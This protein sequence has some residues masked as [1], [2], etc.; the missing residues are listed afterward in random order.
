MKNL[1][2]GALVWILIVSATPA[3]GAD[4]DWTGVYVG[5]NAGVGVNDSKYR[6]QTDI[7]DP[8]PGF[9]ETNGLRE[10]NQ[11]LNDTAFTGG[12]QAGYNW[13]VNRFVLASSLTSTTTALTKQASSIDLWHPRLRGTSSIMPLN[14]STGSGP[15]ADVSASRHCR[16]GL[17]TR[18]AALRTAMSVQRRLGSSRLLRI[19]MPVLGRR[20]CRGGLLAPAPNGGLVLPGRPS[21]SICTSTWGR[22]ATHRSASTPSD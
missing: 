11:N 19:G 13:H 20:L 14:D 5:V 4:Y 8:L 17:C 12:A 18:R 21:S 9:A 15:S 7:R 22:S 1:L 10:E 2:G 6:I 16:S 3:L